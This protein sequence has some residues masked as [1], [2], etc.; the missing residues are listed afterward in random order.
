MAISVHIACMR[1][2]NSL[3]RAG[4]LSWQR[5][6]LIAVITMAAAAAVAAAAQRQDV[7]VGVFAYQGERAAVSDWSPL[8]DYLNRT[9]PS[10]GFRLQ[11][12][13]A[14]TLKTAIAAGQVDLVITNPGYYIGLESE[15]GLSRIA[16]L[17]SENS[18]AVGSVILTRSDRIDLNTIADLAG[19]RVA[20]VSPEAFAGYLIGAREMRDAGV[21]P[22]TDLGQ[23]R[24]LGLPMSNTID[25]INS[26]EVDAGIVKACLPEQMMRDGRLPP[27]QLKAVSPRQAQGFPC[28]LSSRLY[29]DWPIAVTRQTDLHLSKAV[30]RALLSMPEGNGNIS[31]SVPADYRPVDDL[32]RAMQLGPYAYLRDATPQGLALRFWRWIVAFLLLF[33]VWALHTFRVR[34]MVTRRTE[35]LQLSLLAREAAEHRARDNQNRLD[36]LSRLSILGELSGNLAHEINQPLTTIAT[37]ARSVLRRQEAGR[38]TPDAITEACSEIAGEAARAGGIVQRIRGFAKKRITSRANVDVGEIAME[39]VRLMRAVLLHPSQIH[40]AVLPEPAAIVYA[41]ALQI[42]QVLLNLLKNA[43]DATRELPAQRQII[44][45][46]FD[47]TDLHVITQVADLGTGLDAFQYE[48]LFEAFFTTKTD[49]LGLGLS[50][51]KSIIEAHGGRLWAETNPDKI[52]MRFLFSLPRHPT[53]H[54]SSSSLQ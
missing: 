25:A 1:K 48:H 30:A 37:Y 52:G 51:S 3:I 13:D 33:A 46:S 26:G 42:Q 32:Y 39:A 20:A 15:F 23:L 16:T 53:V 31:W 2:F 43:M 38:L 35:E 24:F 17:S 49:G 19:K 28:M 8:I 10:Y 14:V 44:T 34:Q 7:V 5:L 6:A 18:P 47:A 50:I 29:P 54:A 21:D 22:E 41:D 45:I 9:L 40:V 4:K 11:N 36:H 27:S 12:Y